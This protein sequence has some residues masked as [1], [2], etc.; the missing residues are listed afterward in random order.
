MLVP[1]FK[2]TLIV[3]Y[4]ILRRFLECYWMC[5]IFSDLLKELNWISDTLCTGS[6]NFEISL[7]FDSSPVSATDYKRLV[8]TKSI[9]QMNISTCINYSQYIKIR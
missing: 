3:V 6:L 4:C 8:V 5:Y 1:V 2:V 9:L 7:L